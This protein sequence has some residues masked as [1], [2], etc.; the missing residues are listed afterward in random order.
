MYVCHR[1]GLGKSEICYQGF[2]MVD[3]SYSVVILDFIINDHQSS[4]ISVPYKV[5]NAK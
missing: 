3:F 5:L 4:K 1:L 2:L